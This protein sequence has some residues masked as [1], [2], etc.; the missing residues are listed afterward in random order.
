MTTRKTTFKMYH[1]T[2]RPPAWLGNNQWS[3]KYLA[4]YVQDYSAK[5]IAVRFYRTAGQVGWTLGVRDYNSSDSR[6]VQ[7]RSLRYVT[8]IVALDPVNIS[9]QVYIGTGTN[10]RM[11]IEGEVHDYAEIHPTAIIHS[12]LVA[13]NST[14][15]E[16]QPTPLGEHSL[17]DIKSVIVRVTGRMGK[18]SNW[19]LRQ[20]GGAWPPTYATYQSAMGWYV[21]GVDDDGIFETYTDGD[22]AG[23]YVQFDEVGYIT[24]GSTVETVLTP[25]EENPPVSY[26]AYA[27]LNYSGTNQP[28]AE[29]SYAVGIHWYALTTG[30][31]FFKSKG[32]GNPAGRVAQA[33]QV[34]SHACWVNPSR[35]V[36]YKKR[37]SST[38]QYIWWW[39][40]PPPPTRFL[41]DVDHRPALASLPTPQLPI[42]AATGARKPLEAAP[43]NTETP[44]DAAAD[45][46][47][48]FNAETETGPVED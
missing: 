23:G 25:Q 42:E 2:V 19:T 6:I 26:P 24:K 13:D 40:A 37:Y 29:D 5:A 44:L 47:T 22:G 9:I 34:R 14:F 39:E 1:P 30:D 41:F 15:V 45:V 18:V 28:I 12:A 11:Y 38:R 21:V 4:S 43:A 36:V 8:S 31:A 20:K 48:P 16:R 3:T 10:M 33:N 35:E 17:S 27:T 7:G 32:L 46:E